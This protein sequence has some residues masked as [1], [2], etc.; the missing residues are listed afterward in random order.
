MLKNKENEDCQST[1]GQWAISL[2]FFPS[3]CCRGLEKAK[4]LKKKMKNI[5]FSGYIPQRDV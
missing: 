3:L 4:E 2:Q 1:K 5:L